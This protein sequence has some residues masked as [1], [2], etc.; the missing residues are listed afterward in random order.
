MKKVV[1]LLLTFI[2]L[3]G[4][5]A[6]GNGEKDKEDGKI[7]VDMSKYPAA[8]A[9]WSG[10]N[11]IDFFKDAGV[12]YD[13]NGAETWL[14]DHVDYWPGTPVNE[15]A[16]WWTDDGSSMVMVFVLKEDIEDSSKADYD[17]WLKAATET[18]KLPGDYSALQAD[19]VVGNVIFSFETT[20]LDDAVYNKMSDAYKYLVEKIGK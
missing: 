1:A 6:C 12:F 4:L 13:G 20:I 10:Q 16:G 11:F 8:I 2:M 19:Y 14:Q 15:C 5:V 7:S 9:E 3:L 17:A 18:K